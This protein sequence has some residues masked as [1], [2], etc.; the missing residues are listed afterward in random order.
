[1]AALL[2][3]SGLALYFIWRAEYEP[4]LQWLLTAILLAFPIALPLALNRQINR[5][6]QTLSNLLAGIREGDY[7]INARSRGHDAMALVLDEANLLI[8][9]MREQRLGAVEATALLQ[10]VMSEIEVAVFTFDHEHKLRLVNRSGERL[11]SQPKERLLGSAA[12]A[13]DLEEYLKGDSPRTV[14]QQFAGGTGRWRISR[15][16]IREQG[17]PHELLV[18][19]DLS[20]ELREEER[21]AWQRLVRVFGHELN[22]SLAPIK[23]I[24]GSLCNLL[25]QEPQPEDM[26]EDLDRGLNVVASRAE[27]L[28]RFL[29]NFARLTKLPKPQRKPVE[30]DP[31]VERVVQLETRLEVAITLSETTTLPID[32]DQIEQ[33]L[34]NLIRNAVDAANEGD[35]PKVSIGWIQRGD[36]LELSITDNGPGLANTA[37]LFVPF[38]TTKPKGSGIGLALSRQI[39]EQ[40][41]GTLDLRNREETTGCVASIRLPLDL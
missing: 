20:R 13:L 37:N 40:H 1:L 17:Q 2:P 6:L 34:I 21:I 10:T 41:N 9:V 19:S 32:G 39:V 38:F 24:A 31:L 22:N 27:S 12:A 23:S 35:T 26:K 7:S 8:N 25:K 15:T 18:I 30:I 36:Q 3:A 29:G 4:S 33:V 14:Q 16:S 5:P 28:D 11:L